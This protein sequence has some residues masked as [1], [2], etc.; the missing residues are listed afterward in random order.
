VLGCTPV[1]GENPGV[2]GARPSSAGDWTES[3]KLPKSCLHRPP[4][5]L[6]PSV[7]GYGVVEVTVRKCGLLVSCWH[8]RYTGLP[9]A[10]AL[11]CLRPPLPELSGWLEYDI[12][13]LLVVKSLVPAVIHDHRRPS[14]IGGHA[15][16]PSCGVR[17]DVLIMY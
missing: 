16:R 11:M 13:A 15:K 7:G 10:D 5:M 12:G 2:V 9:E 14:L 6:V 1:A 4:P 8:A 3:V 17:A